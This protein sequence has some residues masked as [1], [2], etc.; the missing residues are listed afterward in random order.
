MF[1]HHL[2]LRSPF[3]FILACSVLLSSCSS[4]SF[5]L[6]E[7]TSIEDVET[8][9]TLEREWRTQVYKS[10]NYISLASQ[11]VFQN[12]FIYWLEYDGNLWKLDAKSGDKQLLSQLP[13]IGFVG[14]LALGS[15][16]AIAGS[17]Q[18][19]LY[20]IS[21]STGEILATRS[22]SSSF[23]APALITPEAVFVAADYGVFALSP[24]FSSLLWQQ[25]YSQKSQYNLL[26]GA[27]PFFVDGNL[28][29]VSLADG[30]LV[31]L[32]AA[33]GRSLFKRSLGFSASSQKSLVFD[34]HDINAQPQVVSLPSGAAKFVY[35]SVKKGLLAVDL[36]NSARLDW[37]LPEVQSQFQPALKDGRILFS[38]TL[39]SKVYALDGRTGETLWETDEL[40]YRDIGRATYVENIDTV[41]FGDS[42]GNIIGLDAAD[43]SINFADNFSIYEIYPFILPLDQNNL[44]FV[45][46]NGWMQK[47]RIDIR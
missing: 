43:G 32:D 2:A 22:F 19:K 37:S 42:Y 24:D 29:H 23:Q 33:D 34:L 45:D 12:G 25:N 21:L 7:D 31:L 39:D 4:K 1:S 16:V 36:A 27:S 13:S 41:F 5:R 11:P 20:R 18:G 8:S 30:S 38:N 26:G 10:S 35:P 46:K 47:L 9:F 6:P 40:L 44:V 17:I 3:V 28:L 15:D 14:S